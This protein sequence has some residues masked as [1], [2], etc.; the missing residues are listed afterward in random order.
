MRHALLRS[1]TQPLCYVPVVGVRCQ[2][3]DVV[4]GKAQE[5]ALS[6]D[7]QG[8]G[9]AQQGRLDCLALE[10]RFLRVAT[11]C[12]NSFGLGFD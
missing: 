9:L 10:V 6:V 4:V 1:W 2:S 8:P 3:D 5:G 11:F 7:H 12:P